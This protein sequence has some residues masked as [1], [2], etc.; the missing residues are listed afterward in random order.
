[1]KLQANILLLLTP[2]IV[3]PMLVLGW[4]AYVQLKD[5]SEQNTFR[6]MT[7]TLRQLELHMVSRL[8]T[9]KANSELFSS[10]PLLERYLQTLGSVEISE[11]VQA[12]LLDLFRGYQEA[13]PGYYEIRVLSPE[14]REYARSTS[15]SIPNVL[16]TEGDTNYFREMERYHGDTFTRF[17][18]N[19]DNSEIALLVGRKLWSSDT[20]G[21]TSQQEPELIAYLAITM[22]VGFLEN[23]V[24]YD[25]LGTGSFLF[26]TDSQGNILLHPDA[27]KEDQRLPNELFLTFLQQMSEQ[28]VLRT[29]LEGEMSYLQGTQVDENLFLFG[30][31]SEEDFVAASQRLGASVAG[32]TLAAILITSG[33]LFAALKKLLISPVRRLRRAASDIGKGNLS[34]QI[35]ID[36]NDEIGDLA[37]SFE[38]MR[39]GL[40]RSS[41]QIRHLAYHD[42]LTGLPNRR[43][44]TEVLHHVLAGAKRRQQLVALLFVDI[45]DFKRVNDA[46]GHPAGDL[47]LKE[48]SRRLAECVRADDYVARSNAEST[49]K[50]VARLGGD[51]FIVVLPDIEHGEQVAMVASRVITSLSK[52]FFIDKDECHISVSI[53]IAI[54]PTDG[55]N[56][57]ELVKNADVAMYHAKQRGR[58]S[59]Q[60]YAESMNAAAY[61]QLTL[62]GALRKAIEKCEFEL[63][64]QPLIEARTG[65]LAGA[66]ALLRWRHPDR[67]LLYP[68]EFIPLAERTGLI[69]SID[70]WVLKNACVQAKSWQRTDSCAVSVSVN[71][72]DKRFS[73]TNFD[74]VVARTITDTKL[75]ANCLDLELTENSIVQAADE[76][77]LTLNAFREMGVR[78][79]MDD[80]GTGYSSLSSLSRLPIN[81]VKIDRS[82]VSDIMT[83]RDGAAIIS[84]IIR[85]SRSLNLSVTAEGVENEIQLGLLR[86]EGCDLVQGNLISQ[87]VPEDQMKALM[88]KRAT[89]TA[90]HGF[91]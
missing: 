24:R 85:M 76:T 49:G 79:S 83:D 19:P 37:S 30:A 36:R 78:I 21:E 89:W 52:S 91:A 47:L 27:Q 25:R 34:T 41:E 15:R 9:A 53:G 87:P 82:F 54:Y 31:L 14:G 77:K 81:G 57:S 11:D 7:A 18:R 13:Y 5:I 29:E 39:K 40:Q 73:E 12:A 68:S 74:Q 45:D 32:I 4:V 80:F 60:F 2:S 58:D 6:Q 69:V 33:L 3:L 51:E 71:V 67:G 66:E 46:L 63:H 44:F 72:S 43:M 56:V 1:M 26:F 10:A 17:F 59:Y 61:D 16:E 55:E 20:M 42:S 70:E 65:K 90:E 75:D 48:L 86:A 50:T 62:E 88:D 8:Q 22:D 64:Y 35:E 38:E 28:E 84:A 23:Q